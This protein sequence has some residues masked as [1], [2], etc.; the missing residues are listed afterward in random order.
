MLRKAI[1]IIDK[2]ID[3]VVLIVSLLF[4]LI[5]IYAMY[6]AIMVY[7]N[8]NDAS[9]LKYKPKGKKTQLF[10]VNCLRTQLRG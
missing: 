9:V 1:R 6:D 2:G 8:A 4:F 3:R 5:C 10:C 7:Y